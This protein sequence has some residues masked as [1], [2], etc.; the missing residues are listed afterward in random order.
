MYFVKKSISSQYAILN[1]EHWTRRCIWKYMHLSNPMT[2]TCSINLRKEVN[3]YL[4]FFNS[5][6]LFFSR[7][8]SF[9]FPPF[10][11]LYYSSDSGTV[12][13][14]PKVCAVRGCTCFMKWL[15]RF[16]ELNWKDFFITLFHGCTC[17]CG[18]AH[19]VIVTV[20]W[21]RAVTDEVLPPALSTFNGISQSRRKQDWCDFFYSE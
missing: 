13:W 1:L 2:T 8:R 21:V 5:T 10:T 19:D 18:I 20:V 16:R 11:N 7:F 12:G 9:C 15:R 14:C 6:F 17:C 3:L 4:A